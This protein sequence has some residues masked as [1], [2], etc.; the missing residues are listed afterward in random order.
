MDLGFR[1]FRK[2]FGLGFQQLMYAES[3]IFRH[4]EDFGIISHHVQQL[5]IF[6]CIGGHLV[7]PCH[8]FLDD[9]CVIDSSL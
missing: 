5:A 7:K 3:E 6:R 8:A 2:G 9:S 1:G 4:G